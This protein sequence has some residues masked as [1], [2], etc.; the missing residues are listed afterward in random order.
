MASTIRL[1]A[2][3]QFVQSTRCVGMRAQL[4]VTWDLMMIR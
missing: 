2:H 3:A 4:E 1:P